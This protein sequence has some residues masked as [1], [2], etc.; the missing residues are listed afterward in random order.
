MHIIKIN[1]L[2]I[3][4]SLW[5]YLEK[6]VQPVLAGLFAFVDTNNNLDTLGNEKWIDS[7]WISML[8]MEHVTALRY[9]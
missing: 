6:I 1:I 9:R 8:M 4:R 3:R 5:Q 2:L 7:V